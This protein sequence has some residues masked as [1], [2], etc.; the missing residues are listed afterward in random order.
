[1]KTLTKRSTTILQEPVLEL[2]EMEIV[3]FF[4]GTDYLSELWLTVERE[5]PPAHE[6]EDT[7]RA[8]QRARFSYD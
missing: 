3:D 6:R 8:S 4:P 7:K 2:D 1:M 5:A